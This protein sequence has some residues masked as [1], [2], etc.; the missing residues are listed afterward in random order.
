MYKKV[1]YKKAYRM[2]ESSTPLK[3][4]CG[5]L[6][7]KRCCLGDNNAGMHLYPGEEA[8]LQ[9]SQIFL[10]IRKENFNNIEIFFAVCNG[11]CDRR[12]RP[13]SCRIYP[14][15]SHINHV[16]QISIIDD[17]RAKYTC[18]LLLDMNELQID[19]RYV[20]KVTKVF[21]LLAQDAE[22]RTYINTLSGVLNDYSRFTG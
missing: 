5:I 21:Q 2:L 11:K 1:L 17:P 22:I 16:G 9:E 19:K 8:V 10:K 20:R 13:L 18:P 3:F 4:D 6:C 14:F 12:F 15:I 7:N